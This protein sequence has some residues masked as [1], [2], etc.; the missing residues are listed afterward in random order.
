MEK[1]DGST[2]RRKMVRDTLQ[3]FMEERKE[4][5]ANGNQESEMEEDLLLSRLL[6]KV[7][8]WYSTISLSLFFLFSNIE[9]YIIPPY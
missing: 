8:Y 4:N 7:A 1:E 5:S 6:S 3:Q 2:E 9:K